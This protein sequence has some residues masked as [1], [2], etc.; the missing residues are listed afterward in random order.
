MFV[1]GYSCNNDYNVFT[2]E[3]QSLFEKF[4]NMLHKSYNQDYNITKIIKTETDVR[5]ED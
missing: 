5:G 2:I 3:K 1:F 4:K